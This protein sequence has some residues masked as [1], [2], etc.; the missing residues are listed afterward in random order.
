MV[1]SRH[2]HDTNDRPII[3]ICNFT[4]TL[5]ENYRIG[6]PQHGKYVELLNSDSARYGGS[7]SILGDTILDTNPGPWQ[8]QAQFVEL[9]IASL[10]VTVLQL[11]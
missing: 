5:R 9:N 10:A 1:Y 8:G 11:R 7:N 3:V 2:G 4:P 6:V